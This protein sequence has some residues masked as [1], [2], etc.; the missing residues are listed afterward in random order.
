MLTEA[1]VSSRT[2]DVT[3]LGEPALQAG[4]GRRLDRDPYGG[5]SYETQMLTDEARRFPQKW[6]GLRKCASGKGIGERVFTHRIV[7]NRFWHEDAW[8]VSC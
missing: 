3:I 6:A 1:R 8:A 2:F 4:L 7:H 5:R